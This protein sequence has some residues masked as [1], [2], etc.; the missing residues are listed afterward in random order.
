M[1]NDS[2]KYIKKSIA[3][4][5]NRRTVGTNTP[6]QYA[7]RQKQYMA[8]RVEK[9]YAER[10]YL[11]TDYVI[12]EV[13]GLASDFYEWRKAGIRMADVSS[14]TAS[15]TK[16]AD[17]YKL[18]YF[19]ELGIDYIPIGAKIK[20]MGS[21]WIAT[22]PQNMST[23]ISST[24][25][26]RCNAT[27]NSFDEYGNVVVEPIVVEKYAML[28]NDNE[29]PNNMVLMDGYYNIT[30][31]LNDNTKK[32]KQNSRIILGDKAYHITGV[33]D[34]IQEFS[35]DRNSCRL[36]TFTARVEEPDRTDDITENFIAGGNIHNYLA[37]ISGGTELG[38]GKSTQLVAH[39]VD[40]GVEV[41]NV[42]P[43]WI[44]Q[45]SDENVATVTSDGLVTAISAGETVI[46]A[47]LS[48]NKGI[49]ATASLIVTDGEF[50]P[51]IEFSGAI[52]QYISQFSSIILDIDYFEDGEF[53]PTGY[54]LIETAD[55]YLFA[56]SN[57]QLYQGKTVD[58]VAEWSFGGAP[59]YCY[60]VDYSLDGNAIQITCLR[61]SDE[62]LLV[63]ATCNG[64]S[65][66]IQV[67][68]V[69]Y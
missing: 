45:S 30:C 64:V 11:A 1:A 4:G 26:A 31:Q 16:K 25:V 12:A 22:N 55:G 54:S 49:Y 13:Q 7:S 24:I 35:G 62:P 34:F 15:S 67:E 57:G 59:A 32:L 5:G 63:T 6:T 10:S 38:V 56:D 29:T 60:S 33:T 53:E 40:N 14:L 19:T 18:V 23:A 52:P 37:E 20:A 36:L 47:V 46:K 41:A 66:T 9:F 61:P 51:Y 43:T 21:I 69:G 42:S 17:D 2:E 58:N 39:F 68:L 8:N 65:K 27:Y 28:G 44:W 48:Q 50:A 3:F